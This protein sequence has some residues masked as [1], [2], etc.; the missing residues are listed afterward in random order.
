[1]ASTKDILKKIIENIGERKMKESYVLFIQNRKGNIAATTI[2][3]FRTTQQLEYAYNRKNCCKCPE[4]FR[5]RCEIG[6]VVGKY[7]S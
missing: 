7:N 2:K 5:C 1:M 3:Q 6:L 4:L